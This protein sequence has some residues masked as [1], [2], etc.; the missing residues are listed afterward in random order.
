MNVPR[1]IWLVAGLALVAALWESNRRVAA[2]LVLLLALYY[3][4]VAGRR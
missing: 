4:M 2:A 1:W 3:L